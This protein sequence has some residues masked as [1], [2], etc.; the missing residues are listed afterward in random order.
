MSTFGRF[1]LCTSFESSPVSVNEILQIPVEDWREVIIELEV[2]PRWPIP[3]SSSDVTSYVEHNLDG[4][5]MKYSRYQY[6]KQMQSAV[7]LVEAF[8]ERFRPLL[9][10]I[11]VN[12]NL[13]QPPPPAAP[14]HQIGS[15][16][17]PIKRP[18][19]V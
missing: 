8:Y 16:I 18:R 3:T 17:P 15:V 6:I 2:L 11:T 19:F 14:H 1:R 12:S 9:R 7:N 5:I 10:N 13:I 4:V